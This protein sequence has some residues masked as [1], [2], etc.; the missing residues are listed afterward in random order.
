M[1]ILKKI[2]LAVLSIL[3]IIDINL[4]VFAI[5]VNETILNPEFVEYELEKFHAYAKIKEI[6]FRN[7]EKNGVFVKIINESITEEWI[8]TRSRNLIYNF[9]SYLKSE[10]DRINLSVSTSEV[11]RN[12]H[13]NIRKDVTNPVYA[14][15]MENELRNFPDE[16]DLSAYLEN[17]IKGTL[18]D[19]QRAVNYFYLVFYL[20]IAIAVVIP[21]LGIIIT[22]NLKSVIRFIGNSAFMGGL[23]SYG[24]GILTI[25]MLSRKFQIGEM[26]GTIPDDIVRGILGDIF[27][28]VKIYGLILLLSGAILM[29]LSF[30]INN[31]RNN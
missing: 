1:T 28:P 16:V 17:D 15:Y 23:I 30:F 3:L 11:K 5:S 7:F 27:E 26:P 20:L 8:K 14:D 29:I 4:I 31:K 2:S 9:F 22:R 10:D 12:I 24:T 18:N 13:D 6:T 19:L 21:I 25:D